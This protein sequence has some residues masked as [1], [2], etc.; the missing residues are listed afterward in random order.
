MKFTIILILIFSVLI[1]GCELNIA[2]DEYNT[3]QYI[4]ET[5]Q[6]TASS[7]IKNENVKAKIKGQLYYDVD[8]VIDSREGLEE[9]F[10]FKLSDFRVYLIGYSRAYKAYVTYDGRF[11]FPVVELDSYQVIVKTKEYAEDEDGEFTHRYVTLI[12]VDSYKEFS[13]GLIHPQKEY[14]K[15]ISVEKDIEDVENTEEIIE[16]PIED[17][18]EDLSEQNS[19]TSCEATEEQN[20]NSYT[21]DNSNFVEIIEN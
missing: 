13:L 17:N 21:E 15:D 20:N 11:S 12:D 10:P 8:S 7:L 18:P 1:S 6:D 2:E 5:K 4:E 14:L 3:Q 16:F 19:N 9:S